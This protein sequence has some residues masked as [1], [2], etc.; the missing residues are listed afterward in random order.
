MKPLKY[1]RNERAN[2]LNSSDNIEFM[3]GTGEYILWQGKPNKRAYIINQFLAMLPIALLW[4][5][6]D[7]VF[8]IASFSA[9]MPPFAKIGIMVFMCVHLIPF[10]KWLSNVLTASKRHQNTQYA[11]TNRRILIRTG[12]IGVEFQSISYMDIQS[13]NLKKGL[14]DKMLRVGDLY[15]ISSTLKGQNVFFDI[16][17]PDKVYKAVQKLVS[18][19]QTDIQ[20]PNAYR[21]DNN[22]GYNTRIEPK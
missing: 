8:I 16:E 17:E 14:V 13:V 22:P 20:F 3:L 12:L 1:E 6:F 10:W 7:S 5:A 2:V 4:L 15:F 9:D 18:D 19:I 21:P 11:L